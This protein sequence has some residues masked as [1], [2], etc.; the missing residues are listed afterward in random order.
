MYEIQG[1]PEDIN[2][3]EFSHDG[4]IHFHLKRQ[5]SI[6]FSGQGEDTREK[7]KFT[8]LPSARGKSS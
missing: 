3:G 8:P 5:K 2:T 6:R 7:E 4:G 1:V